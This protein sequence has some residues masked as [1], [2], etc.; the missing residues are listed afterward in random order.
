MV[1]PSIL[2]HCPVLVLLVFSAG[3][4]T[5]NER[6][7][8]KFVATV[9]DPKPATSSNSVELRSHS[10]PAVSQVAYEMAANVDTERQT[11]PD[12]LVPRP[13]RV[14]P[15]QMQLAPATHETLKP[16]AESLLLGSSSND[17]ADPFHGQAELS[18][19]QL[20]AVVQARNPSLQAASAAWRAA[21]ERYPQV[22]SFDDPMF[23]GMLGPQGIGAED[24]GGWMV[25]ASQAVPWAG[26]RALRGNAA[27]AEAEALR[28]DIGDTRLRLAEAARTAY[29]DY[30][31]A[32]R[33]LEVNASTQRLLE[34]FRGIARDKYQVNQATEQDFLQA[35]VE[36]AS[37]ESRRTELVRDEQVAI[38]R[39]NTL[40]HRAAN[41]P[42]PPPP[43][44][45][46]LPESPPTVDELQ[47]M[48]VHSR[49]DLFAQQARIRSERANLALACKEYYPDL[50][51]VAKYDGF[52]PEEMRPQVGIDVNVPVRYARRSAAEREAAD[53]L[54]QRCAEYQN[55][56]DQTRYEV[57][58][59]FER[60]IQSE[61]A[62]RLFEEKILPAAQRNLD[63]ALA[64][65]ASGNLDFLR[66]LDAERQLNT[67]RDMYF[68]AIAEYHRRVAELARVVGEPA[69]ALP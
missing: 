53:R 20:V 42:L 24:G 58:S 23:T 55:L 6:G 63:S 34:Q 31:L 50:N 65:Y 33:Q 13:E 17:P 57:Q 19:E 43:A 16:P 47:Q 41:H 36:L 10:A 22:V 52:M 28:G 21:A 64:N 9:P 14:L 54:Q 30:Y 56:L 46:P 11:T 4:V 35:D 12:G 8:P 15:E 45:A 37:L 39:I 25:Q 61:R 38:A 3:C 69:D 32:R 2:N 59:A 5:T 44:K 40:L 27:A 48:A 60:T 18:V 51:L 66:L 49:P 68:Q 7:G 1:R 29:Y 62:V 26:K 67:Q